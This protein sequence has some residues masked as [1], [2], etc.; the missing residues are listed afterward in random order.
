MM[1]SDLPQNASSARAEEAPLVIWLADDAGRSKHLRMALRSL[2]Y[3]VRYFQVVQDCLTALRSMSDAW[4]QAV[5]LDM[6][7][8]AHLEACACLRAVDQ[9]DARAR[10][11]LVVLSAQDGVLARLQALNAG[12]AR[13]LVQPLPISQLVD[14]LDALIVSADGRPVQV[15]LVDADSA[16]RQVEVSVLRAAGM[17]VRVL[18]DPLRLLEALAET[19]PDVVLIHQDLPQLQGRDL[20]TLLRQH[21]DWQHVHSLV[22]LPGPSAT[23]MEAVASRAADEG[24]VLPTSAEH[25]VGVVMA[26]AQ[27]ARQGRAMQRRLDWVRSNRDREHTVLDQHAIVSIADAAGRITYVNQKF[28]DISGYL[29]HEL[30]GRNHRIVK[31]EEHPADF[32]QHMWQTIASGQVWTGEVCNRRRDGSHYWVESTITPFLD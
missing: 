12:A 20:A 7:A 5:V 26:K 32:Y 1:T 6:L 25:L 18:T 10:L 22:L 14:S 28:C 16:Q 8:P 23:R 31:S 9:P 24:V 11:P 4:P 13:Y 2:G 21:A 30:L 27:C 17:Q 19:S 3:R 15:L 29:E